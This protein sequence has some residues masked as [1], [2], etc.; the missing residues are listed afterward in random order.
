M[1]YELRN[2]YAFILEGATEK[3]F[4][5]AL[6]QHICQKRGAKLERVYNEDSPDISY[7][8]T[9]GDSISIIKFHTVNTIT[10]MPR[11]D[12]WFSAQCVKKYD[13]QCQWYVFLCYDTDSYLDNI[14]KFHQG[15]WS[16]LRK[17]IKEAKRIIDLS[18]S[19]DIEDIMLQ[20][21]PGI[22]S[23][24]NCDMPLEL[25]GRNGKAK[26]KNLLKSLP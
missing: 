16:V 15:D 4:Y 25:S 18:A 22:C 7:H 3:E 11:A 14:S 5:L 26:M 13:R 10:Q 2:G 19:A 12:K 17:S 9:V 23:F 21:L 24:L 6:L 20:D 1:T 8:L